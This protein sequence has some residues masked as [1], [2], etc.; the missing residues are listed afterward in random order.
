MAAE[1]PNFFLLLELDPSVEDGAAIERRIEEKRLEWSRQAMG[2]PKAQLA[3]KANLALLPE[4][5][6]VLLDPRNRATE[7]QAARQLGQEARKRLLAELDEAIHLL[8]ASGDGWDEALVAKLAKELAP[9]SRE[10]IEKRLSAAGARRAG[11]DPAQRKR[12]ERPRLD[13][14]LARKLR[15]NLDHLGL[16]SLYEF[17]D[18]RPQSSPTALVGRAD[19]KYREGLNRP[20]PTSRDTASNALA[21]LARQVFATDAAK[22]RYDGSL[23]VQA[24]EQLKPRLEEA[25][26]DGRLG[27]EEVDALVQLARKRGVPS[28]EALAYVEDYAANRKWRVQSD[29]APLPAEALQLCGF[30]S[31]LAAAGAQRCPECGESLALPCPRCGAR[32]PSSAAACQGCGAKVG[33]APLVAALLKEAEGFLLD[34][35]L[36]AA[37]ERCDRALQLWPEWQPAVEAR[38]R[39]RS[40]REER[41]AALQEIEGLVA[42]SRLEAAQ[43]ALGRFE[44]SLG[45]AGAEQLRRQVEEGLA[46]AKRLFAQAEKLRGNGAD[47]AEVLAQLDLALAACADFEP[48]LRAAAATPPPP[49]TA[50]AVEVLA[51]GLRLRWRVGPGGDPQRLRYRVLRKLGGLPHG[52]EDGEVVAELAGETLDDPGATVG[53]AWCYAVY[54]VRSEVLS[55]SAATSGPHLRVGEVDRLEV[56]AGDRSA[57]LSWQPP[58][59]CL[60]IEVRRLPGGAAQGVVVPVAGNSAQDSGL[61]NGQT[62]RYQVVALFSD[63]ARPGAELPSPGLT[64]SASPTAPPAPV[65]DLTAERQGDRVHLHWSPVA[66]ARVEIR[67]VAGG[68]R[69]PLTGSVMPAASLDRLGERLGTGHGSPLEATLPGPGRF[70]LVPVSVRSETA[71]VGQAIEVINLEGASRL[72][73]RRAGNGVALTWDWPRGAEAAVAAWAE[74]AFPQDPRG[75]SGRRVRIT[76]AEYDSAGCYLIPHLERRRHYF[77]VFIAVP[78]QDLYAPPATVL[79]SGGQETVARYQVA[80]RRSLLSR[81]VTDAWI[82][83]ACTDGLGTL[84]SLLVVAKPHSV[85]ISA[86][87]GEVVARLDSLPMESGRARIPVPSPLWPKRPYLKLFFQD[88]ECARSIRLLPAAKEQLRVG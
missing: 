20:T 24:M 40:R 32:N 41:E 42:R 35:D 43:A 29:A 67:L 6:G 14:S 77:A 88:P 76:R 59:G 62:Y 30:C 27:R 87:D 65:R 68:A 50:L 47:P 74:E 82:E 80:T 78:G 83:I 58:P 22:A 60:R 81:A 5:R 23:A 54:S 10:E 71:V 79:E 21:G 84:P 53:V 13:P 85:P 17:L 28:D 56:E 61:T 86:G 16:A 44:R 66:D 38:Q 52:A 36:A 51:N 26:R 46:R 9:L 7:A 33:D 4:L 15:E 64:V 11:E 31:A 57:R 12:P 45:R 73:A 69:A 1:R 3:A 72:S 48:A 19:E 49:P 39:A 63:P 37:V 70:W 34:G 55:R 25:G 2:N 75:G 8:R 18:V